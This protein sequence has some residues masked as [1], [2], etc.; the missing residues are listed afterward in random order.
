[1]KSKEL[2]IYNIPREKPPL[3]AMNI[4]PRK[5]LFVLLWMALLLFCFSP[6]FSVLGLVASAICLFA[7][8]A[9][10]DRPLLDIYETMLVVYDDHLPDT[11]FCIYWDELLSWQYIRT[12]QTDRLRLELVDGQHVECD[13]FRSRKLFFYLN[14][15]AHGKEK[16]LIRKRGKNG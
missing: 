3:L 11:C 12:Q 15:L 5:L 9:M 7:L 2:K 14:L 4:K 13:I 1:M 6:T 16:K 8:V 10:P